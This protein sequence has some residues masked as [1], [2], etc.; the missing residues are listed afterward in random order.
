MLLRTEQPKQ[1]VLLSLKVAGGKL[2]HRLRPVQDA[3]A[4]DAFGA[5]PAAFSGG[6]N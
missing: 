3:A 2:Y 4:P 5:R 1:R 6:F